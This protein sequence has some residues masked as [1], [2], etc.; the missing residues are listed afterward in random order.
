MGF[1]S[2]FIKGA[3]ESVDAQLKNDIKRN[4][5][6]V[7]GMAQY[8]IT[9]RRAAIEEQEKE[10]KE[11]KKTLDNLASLVGG[12]AD[13]AA[14]LYMAAGQNI[15]GGNALYAELKK[16]ADA[17]LD[18]GA[19]LTFTNK[20]AEPG[21]ITDY[22]NKFITPISTIPLGQEEVKPVGLMGLFG[23]DSGKK[24]MQ[25]V[26]EAAP[27]PT[28]TPSDKEVGV[29]QIDRTKFMAAQDYA[30]I[31]KERERAAEKATREAQAFVS[32]EAR[33]ERA[34]KLDEQAAALQQKKFLTAEDQRKIDNLRNEAADLRAVNAAAQKAEEHIQN[35]K[36]TGLSIEE[37]EIEIAKAKEHPEFSSYE[38]MAVYADTNLAALEAIPVN[39]RSQK[40]NEE[41][42][43]MIK[44]RDYALEGASV[45]NA[46]TKDGKDTTVFSKQTRDSIINNE[47]KRVLQPL[48]LVKDIEGQLEYSLEG[49]EVEYLDSMSLA[50]GN[51]KKRVDGIDD[52]EMNNAIA[53]QE[54][55]MSEFAARYITKQLDS[56]VAPKIEPDADTIRAKITNGEYEAGDIIQYT[57]EDGLT[58]NFVWT[59]STIL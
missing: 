18:I 51:I 49:N 50:I 59:G 43:A 27:L 3:A 34:L 54:N 11:L 56:G 7:E 41:I 47:I 10:K 24:I 23:G 2:G 26:E 44:L 4:Q 36:L 17:G 14:E 46:K 45:Y 6:R 20:N 48:G 58:H 42:D 53:A 37:K 52:A 19:A 15:D 31:V 5:E 25:R 22:L 16:N 40:D 33:A 9:R 30:E 13:K 8:R 32:S 38:R 12:D 1:L 57:D 21:Q 35:M 55:T 29:A 28:I 39:A